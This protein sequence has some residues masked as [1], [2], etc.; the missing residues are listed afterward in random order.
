M[1][2]IAVFGSTGSIGRQTLSVCAMHPGEFSVHSLVFGRNTKLG[3]EQINAFRPRF[4]GVYDE[5][6]AREIREAFP[7]L[8]VVSG[9]AVW[10]IASY[11]GIDTVVNGVSGFSGTFPLLSALRSGR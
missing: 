2:S 5:A 9:S 8:D 6:A 3:I 11:D 7:G 10:D 4:V 1:K